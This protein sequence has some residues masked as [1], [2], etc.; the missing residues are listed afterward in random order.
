MQGC[1]WVL[2]WMVESSVHVGV[3]RREIQYLH[4]CSR[5]FSSYCVCMHVAVE[6]HND[7]SVC[8]SDVAAQRKFMTIGKLN[9]VDLAGSERVRKEDLLVYVPYMKVAC[10]YIRMY[11]PMYVCVHIDGCTYWDSYYR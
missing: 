2:G 9:L 1:S 3:E 4:W 5:V 11:T 8:V 6:A 7:V 10:T